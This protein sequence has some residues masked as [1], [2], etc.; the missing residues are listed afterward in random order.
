MEFR[1]CDVS[2]ELRLSWDVVHHGVTHVLLLSQLHAEAEIGHFDISLGV[3][4][5]VQ[6][7]ALKL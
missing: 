5:E 3:Q 1:P 4:L 7:R 2:E 6:V